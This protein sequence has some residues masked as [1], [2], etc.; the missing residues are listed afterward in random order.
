MQE[1][2]MCV[3]LRMPACDHV[4]V[5]TMYADHVRKYA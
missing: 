3:C 2:S 4:H 5:P 1:Y